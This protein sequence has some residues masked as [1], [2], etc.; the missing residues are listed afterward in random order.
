[1]SAS[2]PAPKITRGKGIP[3]IWVVPAIAVA[4]GLWMAIRELKNLGPEI[5]IEFADGSG[6]EAGKTTLEYLGVTVGTVEK[7]ALKPRLDG[8]IVQL[9]MKRSAENLTAAGSKFWIVHPKIGLS[10]VSG[11]ETLVSGVRLSVAPGA[12]PLAKEFVG[13]DKAPP[14]DVTD[15]GRAFILVSDKLG[16]LTTGSPVTYRELKVGTVEASRLSDDATRVL[17]RIHID[18]PYSDLV[19]TNTRFW[20][21][22]GFTFKLNLFGAQVKDTSLESLIQGGVAFATPDTGPLAPAAGANAHF[23]LAAE[24]APEWLKWAPKIPIQSSDT[25]VQKASGSPLLPALMK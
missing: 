23:D 17:V 2:A 3:L 18:A 9:R 19:R 11:L 1:M 14:P 16:S 21:S 8:V 12:G 10:G 22:G 15:E 4:I 6:I 25:V 20:N 24:A 13:L 7:V 5:T